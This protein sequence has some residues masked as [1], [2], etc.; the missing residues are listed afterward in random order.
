MMSG[1]ASCSVGLYSRTEM[2]CSPSSSARHRI[3]WRCAFCYKRPSCAR[4]V[5][6]ELGL[7]HPKHA[8]CAWPKSAMF[9]KMLESQ[10]KREYG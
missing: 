4:S 7:A 2:T 8:M 5:S 10:P 3:T 6:Q 1:L 9:S